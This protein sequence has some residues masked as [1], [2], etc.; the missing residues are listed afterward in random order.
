MKKKKEIQNKKGMTRREFLV[1]T[2]AATG[3][4]LV[5]ASVG[6]FVHTTMAK[7]GTLKISSYGGSYQESQR[8]AFF[9]PFSKEFGVQII[10]DS[11]ADIAKVKAQVDTKTYEW[12]VVDLETRHVARGELE[13]LLEPI[14][15]NVVNLEAIDKKAIRKAAIG[16]IFWT[17][18]LAYNKKALGDKKP[19]ASWADFW[20]VKNFPGPRALQDQAPFNLE[21][22][23]LADG[24]PMDKIYPIDVDRAFKKMDEIKDNIT[25][26]WKNGAQQI[27]LLTSA[28]AYYSSAWNGRVNVAQKKGVPL[29]I[30]WEGGCLD[31]DWWCVP[32]GNPNKDLAMKFINFALSAKRQGEQMQKWIAYGPTNLNA[33]KYITPERAKELPSYPDNLK[34]QFVQNADYWGPNLAPL[35]EKWKTWIIS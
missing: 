26:W 33:F 27:Q 21:F 32:R 18:S 34:K 8:K 3:A 22:A 31:L 19:A 17:T 14:D 24:V 2:G 13:N 35:T 9:E 11:G 16:D 28:E 6:P 15:T 7:G 1:T 10:E 5:T 29:E 12:D 4:A 25:V 30:V 20:D 23:L